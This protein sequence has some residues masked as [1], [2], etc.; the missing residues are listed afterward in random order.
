M[1][2]LT[3]AETSFAVLSDSGEYLLGALEN[4]GNS[5]PTHLENWGWYL[6]SATENN[7]S[8]KE[9]VAHPNISNQCSLLGP[10]NSTSV[11]LQETSNS[12][13]LNSARC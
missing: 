12:K 4:T 5:C 8:R 9:E 7:L 6:D 10:Q 13:G 1:T 11:P 3:P 2:F